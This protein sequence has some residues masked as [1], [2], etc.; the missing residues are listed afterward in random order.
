ME[1]TDNLLK[2]IENGEDRGLSELN[3]VL[4][5]MI[6]SSLYDTADP[7]P[8]LTH[9]NLPV[10]TAIL[11]RLFGFNSSLE[12]WL[13]KMNRHTIL[14]LL[15]P[16]DG[17]L[18]TIF[19][20][21]Y[22][23][24]FEEL[25]PVDSSAFSTDAMR[26][27][28]DQKLFGTLSN[29]SG[30]SPIQ[31]NKKEYFFCAFASCVIHISK[32]HG[33]H[34]RANPFSRDS[35]N[36]ALELLFEYLHWNIPVDSNDLNTVAKAMMQSLSV[37]LLTVYPSFMNNNS[38]LPN[39]TLKL[40]ILNMIIHESFLLNEG[41][42]SQ[43]RSIFVRPLFLWIG[44]TLKN[45][46]ASTNLLDYFK[47]VLEIYRVFLQPW[48][49]LH[50]V[51]LLP[52]FMSN[53]Y[54][55]SWEINRLDF[56][57]ENYA[58]FSV[59]VEDLLV[60]FYR[61]KTNGCYFY[62][63]FLEFLSVFDV[64]VQKAIADLE[65]ICMLNTTSET[66]ALD[67]RQLARFEFLVGRSMVPRD[68]FHSHS[69]TSRYL[70]SELCINANH[71]L[72]SIQAKTTNPFVSMLTST[73]FRQTSPAT[74]SELF[75][76]LSSIFQLDEMQLHVEYGRNIKAEPSIHGT[77]SESPRIGTK[78]DRLVGVVKEI[79]SLPL[80]KR[81]IHSSENELLLHSMYTVASA[82]SCAIGWDM[83]RQPLASLRYLAQPVLFYLVLISFLTILTFL[84]SFR[85]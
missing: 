53:R 72:K 5:T 17:P 8:V 31:L 15:N 42:A 37:I 7:L 57:I 46:F 41:V 22:L 6:G 34:F 18:Y 81:P 76:L 10:F 47:T 49:S 52:Y 71:Q 16:S 82:A 20:H 38:C 13:L 63:P 9:S 73:I 70:A 79:D 75:A 62:P 58:F 40:S 19:T 29:R 61:N 39:A 77:E 59:L 80:W 69:S 35:S 43:V 30:F 36:V 68:L 45:S 21:D 64:A 74:I 44:H 65:N 33:W 25:I 66:I 11:D 48:K 2:L 26:Y 60:W 51:K 14:D 78:Y 54:T 23:T 67:Q 1:K 83:E 50:N 55:S 28:L 27:I 32:D 4:R 56:L 84:M 3:I 24:S 85:F 12:C